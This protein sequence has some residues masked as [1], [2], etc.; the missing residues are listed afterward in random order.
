MVTAVVRVRV[1]YRRA[2]LVFPAPFNIVV[3]F[4][5]LLFLIVYTLL[6]APQI[7]P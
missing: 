7:L 3:T 4:L 2:S 6:L 5:V 1:V